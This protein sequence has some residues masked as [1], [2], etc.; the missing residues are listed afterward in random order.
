ME[1]W[2]ESQHYITGSG[3]NSATLASLTKLMTEKKPNL[4]AIQEAADQWINSITSASD[5]TDNT[6]L[7]NIRYQGIWNLFPYKMSKKMKEI[8][9][10]YYKDKKTCINLASIGIAPEQTN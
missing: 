10:E 2:N 6:S 7:I 9:R 3:G 5:Q 4:D 1:I 8:A